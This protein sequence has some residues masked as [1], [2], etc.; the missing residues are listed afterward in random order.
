MFLG[1]ALQQVGNTRQAADSYTASI[2]LCRQADNIA[3]MLGATLK[4]ATAYRTL[5]EL[6]HAHATL[7]EAWDAVQ[8]QSPQPPAIAYLHLGLANVTYE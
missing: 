5:G 4:L 2:P 7:E 8:S 1:D 6:R 3:A